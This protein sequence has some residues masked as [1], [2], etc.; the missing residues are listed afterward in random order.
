VQREPRSNGVV[1]W[2]NDLMVDL[3]APGLSGS[4]R[5]ISRWP[6]S[7][8][9]DSAVRT[10]R[11]LRSR[12]SFAPFA[13]RCSTSSWHSTRPPSS[14]NRATTVSH[15]SVT[16]H[17]SLHAPPEAWIP[18]LTHHRLLAL[19]QGAEEPG[20]NPHVEHRG[21]QRHPHRR[22]GDHLCA[23]RILLITIHSWSRQC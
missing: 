10:T 11:S 17:L 6:A 8:P 4:A 2:F 1:E 18:H 3:A 13:N 21:G 15:N 14:L 19:P 16:A 22:R 20:W 5:N 12:R 7:E 9:P 23:I